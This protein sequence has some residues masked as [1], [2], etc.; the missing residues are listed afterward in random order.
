MES[1]PTPSVLPPLDQVHGHGRGH[2]LVAEQAAAQY[3]PPRHPT[4]SWNEADE[5]IK[6]DQNDQ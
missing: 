3:V 4:L 5:N 1:F 2:P 6:Q